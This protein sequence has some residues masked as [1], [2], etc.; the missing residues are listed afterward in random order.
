MGG[1]LFRVLRFIAIVILI[2]LAIQCAIFTV[3]YLR[4][5]VR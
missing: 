5:K 1:R 2:L 4:K 3:N